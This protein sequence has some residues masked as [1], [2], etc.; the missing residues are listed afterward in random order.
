MG[1]VLLIDDD[2]I[3]NFL[4]TKALER[5]GAVKEIRSVLNGK[6]AIDL[7]L[8]TDNQNLPEIIFL[9][10]NMPIMDGFAFLEA[11]NDLA[12]LNKQDTRIVIVTS[13]DSPS[14][15]VRAQ[16]LGVKDFLLKPVNEDK[17][18]LVLL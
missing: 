11:Y 4:M 17:L 1:A 2:D 8:R 15:R 14:D 3:C 10:I 9:D 13:S 5:L 18:K 6:Q 7:I 16:S 12:L